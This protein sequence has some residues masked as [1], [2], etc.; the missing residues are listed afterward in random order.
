MYWKD[1]VNQGTLGA[2]YTSGDSI[3]IEF[4]VDNNM[5]RFFKNDTLQFTDSSAGL[6][7]KEWA[8][9]VGQSGTTNMGGCY[10]NTGAIPSYGVLGI[11][12]AGF[13]S[14]C[15]RNLPTPPIKRAEKYF[16]AIPYVGNSTGLQ[17]GEIQKAQDLVAIDQSLMFDSAQSQYLSRTPS[18]AGNRKMWTWSGRVKLSGNSQVLLAAQASNSYNVLRFY[19]M[20]YGGVLY[21]AEEYIQ[22]SQVFRLRTNLLLKDNAKHYHIHIAIDT[23]QTTSSNRI[24]LTIDGNTVTSFLEANYLHRTMSFKLM[25]L[26]LITLEPCLTTVQEPTGLTA[27]CPT[28]ISLIARPLSLLLSDSLTATAIGFQKPTLGATE[29]TALSWISADQR[30][31]HLLMMCQGIATTG[32]RT[33]A[34]R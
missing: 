25:L 19:I 17:V 14:L 33:A 13:K 22:A 11:P 34:S 12:S 29:Q 30:T 27:I 4:D 20:V 28:L 21:I 6:S 9:F 15:T 23:T 3:R 10:L 18:V 26:F 31:K 1:G 7:G 8:V 32:L 16:K 5:L 24:K 2:T